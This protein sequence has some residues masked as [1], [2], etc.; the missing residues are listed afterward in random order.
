M[1]TVGYGD[2]TPKSKIEI[3]YVCSIVIICCG[4]FGYAINTIGG[5]LAAESEKNSYYK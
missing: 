5:I 2:I 4:I 1:C 3:I